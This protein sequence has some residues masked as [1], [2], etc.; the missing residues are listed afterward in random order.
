M[1]LSHVVICILGCSSCVHILCLAGLGPDLRCLRCTGVSGTET[2]FWYMPEQT[3]THE[4]ERRGQSEAEHSQRN[5]WRSEK[6][7]KA[8]SRMTRQ[9]APTVQGTEQTV[10]RGSS[11]LQAKSQRLMCSWWLL[12]HDSW[13]WPAQEGGLVGTMAFRV[14]ESVCR[15]ALA[16]IIVEEVLWESFQETNKHVLVCMLN[17]ERTSQK[18][19]A[20]RRPKGSKDKLKKKISRLKP[21]EGLKSRVWS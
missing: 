21:R 10:A 4:T 15:G 3:R 14:P 5:F 16:K 20:S 9:A 2:V 18:S 19:S 7:K 1:S 13:D 6:E 8:P 11:G 17:G 12:P